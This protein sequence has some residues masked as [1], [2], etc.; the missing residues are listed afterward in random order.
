MKG[1]SFLDENQTMS[2]EEG[3]AKGYNVI[4][5]TIQQKVD[6]GKPLTDVQSLYM[7]GIPKANRDAKLP[8]EE[9]Q[10]WLFS[11]KEEYET[12]VDSIGKS[13]STFS[14]KR[15]TFNDI[16]SISGS[17]SESDES[18]ASE[19]TEVKDDSSHEDNSDFFQDESESQIQSRKNTSKRKQS[20]E[21]G[22]VRKRAIL[23]FE[24]RCNSEENS[25]STKTSAKKKGKMS[26]LFIDNEEKKFEECERIFVPYLSELGKPKLSSG[27]DK[28]HLINI[29]NG[30]VKFTPSFIE[31][32]N[33]VSLIKQVQQ[34]NSDSKR[35]KKLCKAIISKAETIYDEKKEY[36]PID[37]KSE[38]KKSSIGNNQMV[39]IL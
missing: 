23:S 24:S 6:D 34:R 30:V 18:S 37:F 14:S 27:H 9:R 3:C 16:I 7:R 4:P 8:V 35:L 5:P 17:G 28:R 32:Y 10:L 21:A 2:Y 25:Y 19:Q 22:S 26:N 36:D 31:K 1:Y 12:T 33:V 13:A 38:R 39:R 29:L 20:T 15:K 11:F